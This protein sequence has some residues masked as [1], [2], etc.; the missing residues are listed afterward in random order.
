[1]IIDVRAQ[2]CYVYQSQEFY[3][4]PLE[5]VQSNREQQKSTPENFLTNV[6]QHTERTTLGTTPYEK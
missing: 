5:I 1:M 3:L 4:F 6:D 2:S